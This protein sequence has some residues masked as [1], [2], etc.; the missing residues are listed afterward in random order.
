MLVA[1][2]LCAIKR[3]GVAG[4]VLRIA[5]CRV[6]KKSCKAASGAHRMF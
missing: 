1:S 4:A 6:S 5:F 2:I 3:P